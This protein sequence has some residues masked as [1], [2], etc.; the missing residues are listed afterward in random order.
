MKNFIVKHIGKNQSCTE[1]NLGGQRF[2]YLAFE[3]L[4]LSLHGCGSIAKLDVSECV[5]EMETVPIAPFA[6][7]FLLSISND[8]GMG[9]RNAMLATERQSVMTTT[10]QR[11]L[12]GID[13]RSEE[14]ENNRN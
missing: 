14:R 2:G 9:C 7:D 13:V 4:A 11:M 5:K 10:V 8:G 1:L 3:E 6:T 12:D